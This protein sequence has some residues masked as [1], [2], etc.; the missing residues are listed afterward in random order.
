MSGKRKITSDDIY[1]SL[2]GIDDK[3]YA[4]ALE[5]SAASAK[6][7]KRHFVACELRKLLGKKYLWA[8]LILLMIINSVVAWYMAGKTQAAHEPARIIAEFFTDYFDNSE[9]MDAY[10]QD[11]VAFSREQSRLAQEAAMNGDLEFQPDT[12][13]NIYSTDESYSDRKLFMKLYEAIDRSANYPETMRQVINRANANLDE[14]I[15]MGMPEDSFTVRY[16]KKV[17]SLY[18]AVRDNVR[19]GVEYTRGWGEYFDYDV[20][21]IFI[22][23][24]VLM[25]GSLVFADERQVGFLP[26]LRISKNGRGRTAVAKIITTLLL[27]WGITLVFTATTF[28]VYGLRIGYSS[29]AN[30]LQSLSAFTLSPYQISI[31]GYFAVSVGVKLLTFSVFA[32]FVMALSALL[33]DY[34]LIYLSGLGFFGVNFLLY[35]LKY[36]DP[37][38]PF[39]NL[40]LVAV[41]AVNPLFVRYR[42][43]NFFGNVWGYVPCMLTVYILAAVL[44]TV[45]ATVFFVRSAGGNRPAWLDAVTSFVMTLYAKI[46]SALK[47]FGG[48]ARAPKRGYSMSLFTAESYKTLISSRFIF[49][50]ILLFTVKCFYS[51]ST[52]KPVRTYAD[53]VYKEYMTTLEGTLTDEKL[54]YIADERAKISEILSER[55]KMQLAYVNDE[56][57][58]DDYRDYLDEYNYAYS[59]SELLGIV[60]KQAA[61]LAQ[62]EETSGV[63]GWFMYDTGWKKLYSGD[64][65]LF[66]YTCILLLLTGSFASE[67]LSRSSSGGFASILRATKNG[68]DRTFR[69]KLVSAGTIAV[70]LSVIFNAVDILFIFTGYDMPAADA[71]LVSMQM[72]GVGGGGI[73]VGNYLIVFVLM[74]IAAALLMA[75]LVC[76]LSE[77][78]CRYI[79]V[80][81][82]AVMLT[83]LP[84]LFAYFGVAAANRI[85]FLNLLA[86]TPLYLQSV[87]TPLFGCGWAML[88]IWLA[89]AFAAVMALLAPAKK[90][91]VGR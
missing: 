15:M 54:A 13:P 1:R 17:I 72:F 46:K 85:S 75:M 43:A 65:D 62:K 40:N 61:Y 86:G 32:L 11:I 58:F 84:A 42:A 57:S 80:L 88:A 27:T 45:L 20:V 25:L 34:I 26:I 64:A 79:P 10:Y 9:A 89:A 33:Y 69:A 37:S 41:S 59:R 63:K 56:I 74:R 8:F 48:R 36:I 81:G 82:A 53:S 70:A 5:P 24:I 23:F 68:R 91:F 38:S 2:G 22:F 51:A 77:L 18:E 14:F 12:M 60:E 6:K 4:A 35:T 87:G 66:L 52:L 31:G 50:V 49:A 29:P 71:P 30:V 55:D 73:T 67:Y 90:M 39:R 7:E 21:N 28:A 47:K 44:F 16:Q 78:L 83:T 76:A 3:W 19:V